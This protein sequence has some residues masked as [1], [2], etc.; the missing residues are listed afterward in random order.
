M[1]VDVKISIFD[2]TNKI[3]SR[4]SNYIVDV[5]MRQ[6]L[7]TLACLWEMLPQTQFYKDLTR[8]TKKLIPTFVD[9]LGK[10]S[11]G[12]SASPLP[13]SILNRANK[14]AGLRSATSFKSRYMCFPVNFA[15][16]LRTPFDRTTVSS[17]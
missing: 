6:K 12:V 9:G 13:F 4:N 14:V 16:F 3:L 2:A 5:V 15:K 17:T 10:T 7:V 11:K 1:K 8:K